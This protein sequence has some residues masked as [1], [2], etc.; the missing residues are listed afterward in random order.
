[1]IASAYITILCVFLNAILA[2][3][4]QIDDQIPILDL[5]DPFKNNHF[6]LVSSLDDINMNEYYLLRSKYNITNGYQNCSI[7]EHINE[8]VDVD[9]QLLNDT[10]TN[11]LEIVDNLT[12]H[13]LTGITIPDD[14]PVLA[15]DSNSVFARISM[16]QSSIN[17]DKPSFL[18]RFKYNGQIFW[19]YFLDLKAS[20]QQ[21]SSSMPTYN[22][23]TSTNPYGS[24]TH[25]KTAKLKYHQD[26]YYLSLTYDNGSMCQVTGLPRQTELQF[27][28]DKTYFKEIFDV[29]PDHEDLAARIM[30]VNE[31][32]TCNYQILVGVPA[33]CDLELFSNENK[34]FITKQQNKLH[35]YKVLCVNESGNEIS[36]NI[37][38]LDFQPL[39]IGREFILMKHPS[40]HVNDYLIYTNILDSWEGMDFSIFEFIVFDEGEDKSMEFTI[41]LKGMYS[42]DELLSKNGDGVFAIEVFDIMDQYIAT[43]QINSSGNVITNTRLKDLNITN[44][45]LESKH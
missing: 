25:D 11:A 2:T 35:D 4:K 13:Q 38:N 42:A 32:Y 29:Q 26:G 5:P 27:V 41:D 15:I 6:S 7:Y 24:I 43:L 10:L 17:N 28:C 45:F 44:N 9:Q 21:S 3:S 16:G 36:S 30:W 22:L 14:K 19:N 12:N 31:Q 8:R 39:H 18:R 34:K 20:I 1:M 23:G 40:K 33:L 37:H